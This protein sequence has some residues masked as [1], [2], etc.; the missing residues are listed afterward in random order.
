ML[1]AAPSEVARLQST[2]VEILTQKSLT[3]GPAVVKLSRVAHAAVYHL[4][5]LAGGVLQQLPPAVAAA[6]PAA[7]GLLPLFLQSIAVS[8]PTLAPASLPP[9]TSGSAPCHHSCQVLHMLGTLLPLRSAAVKLKLL[10]CLL[11][12]L[13]SLLLLLLLLLPHRSSTLPSVLFCSSQPCRTGYWS[14]ALLCVM[15]NMNAD[16]FL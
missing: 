8:R 9:D 1:A 14:S 2:R 5:S 16:P 13:L 15:V 11:L 10:L 6:T 3:D 4:L 12:V 7:I